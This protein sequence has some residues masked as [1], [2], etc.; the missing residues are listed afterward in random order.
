MAIMSKKPP[1]LSRHAVTAPSDEQEQGERIIEARRL[2]IDLVKPNPWQ[3]R[4]HA[5]A[6]RLAELTEDVKSARDTGTD[7]CATCTGGA[8]GGKGAV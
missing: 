6:G 5:D 3:P 1:A 2:R 7:T 4:R 8:V